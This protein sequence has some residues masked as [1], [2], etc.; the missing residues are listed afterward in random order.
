MW[1]RS[2]EGRLVDGWVRSSDK[3]GELLNFSPFGTGDSVAGKGGGVEEGT[4]PAF[5]EDVPAASTEVSAE[6]QVEVAPEPEPE[7]TTKAK[8]A[9]DE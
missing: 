7:A 9:S 2:K 5:T 1:C 3:R 4:P 6:P 8:L